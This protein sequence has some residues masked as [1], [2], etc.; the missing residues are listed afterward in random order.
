MDL[1]YSVEELKAATWDLIGAN[2]LPECYLRPIAFFGYGTL[3]VVVARQPG[4]RRDHVVALGQLPRRGGPPQRHSREG[5]ELAAH[6]PE[7][8]PACREGDGRLSEL[9]ARSGRGESRRIR[10]GDPA[11]PRRLHRRRLGREHLRGQG[12]CDLH[13]GSLGVDPAGHH[14]R[15]DHPDRAGSRPPCRREAADPHRPLSRRRGVHVRHRRRG[16]ADP[17]GR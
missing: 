8:H 4:R 7:R 3:G 9:D 12:R 10:R 5:L 17:R 13:A 11:D 1:P 16:D 14:A 2:G 15:L 6:R